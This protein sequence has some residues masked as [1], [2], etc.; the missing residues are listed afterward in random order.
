MTS[1]RECPPA[2]AGGRGD[3]GPA[4]GQDERRDRCVGATKHGGRCRA[5]S[6]VGSSYCRHHADQAPPVCAGGRED[7]GPGVGP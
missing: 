6:A 4:A 3:D 2:G 7:D 1:I 5:Y